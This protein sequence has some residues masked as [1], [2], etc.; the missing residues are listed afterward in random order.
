M[1]LASPTSRKRGFEITS[2]ERF[3][4]SKTSVLF[5]LCSAVFSL[6]GE[7]VVQD[8]FNLT[9]ATNVTVAAGDTLRIEY[10]HG[11]PKIF[12]KKGPGRLEVAVIGNPDIRFVV[13]EGTFAT[14]RPKRMDFGND[15]GV[16][17]HVDATVTDSMTCEEKDGKRLISE[18]RDS[19]GRTF[20]KSVGPYLSRPLPYITE[21]GMNGLPVI[22]FGTLKNAA[23]GDHVGYGAAMNWERSTEG[24][25]KTDVVEYFFAWEDDPN[26]KNYKG[27]YRGASIFGVQGVGWLMTRD[28]VGNGLTASMHPTGGADRRKL[29]NHVD[30]I[31][32]P[33]FYPIPDGPH[34]FNQ[35]VKDANYPLYG[36]LGFGFNIDSGSYGG[37][38][39][40]EFIISEKHF[41]AEL[42]ARTQ[43]YLITRWLGAQF[44]YLTVMP[45]ATLD[46][47]DNRVVTDN[48]NVESG[49][50]VTDWDNID[51][52]YVHAGNAGRSASEASRLLADRSQGVQENLVFAGAAG[53][54]SASGTTGALSRVEGVGVLTKTGSG[55]VL[56]GSVEGGLNAIDIK[57]GT[58]RIAPLEAPGVLLRLDASDAESLELDESGDR[59]V[60]GRWNDANGREGWYAVTN[61]NKYSFDNSRFVGKP[62]LVQN[63][64]NGLPAVDFGAY[65]T[66]DFPDGDGGLL[67]LRGRY[68]NS[69][70]DVAYAQNYFLVWQ[71]RPETI[72]L[73]SDER[74]IMGPSYFGNNNTWYRGFGGKG[75]LYPIHYH[76]APERLNNSIKIDGKTTFFRNAPDTAGWHLMDTWVTFQEGVNISLLGA[77]LY[78]SLKNL[79]KYGNSE[80]NLPETVQTPSVKGIYGGVQIAEAVFFGRELTPAYRAAVAGA[81]GA[82]WFGR[83][84]VREFKSVTLADGT[85]LE[86][87]H[88]QLSATNLAFSGNARLDADLILPN[89]AMVSVAGNSIDGFGT[90]SAFSVKALGTG[91]VLLTASDEAS[92]VK[93]SF[94]LFDASSVTG[95]FSRKV[96]KVEGL[97]VQGIRGTLAVRDGGIWLEFGGCGTVVT[98]R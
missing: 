50:T 24:S 61:A 46:T 89:D 22:D 11:L 87:P 65:T 73:S 55:S 97:K 36:I 37:F 31:A 53:L 54:E 98:L 29:N 26:A 28:T 86:M 42:R 81:L 40:G 90:M 85:A 5:A 60:V 35:W 64:L 17:Y 94:K 56:V 51:V 71:D 70:V 30:G 69:E 82:K 27:P 16:I 63:A 20:I 32:V 41:S 45:G 7:L 74:P 76:D 88:S 93:K 79:H 19:S 44:S 10:L 83:D 58:L 25:S 43:R 23:V 34:V 78:A 15:L 21:N 4:M 59:Q 75:K 67:A 2:T 49:A 14:V 80:P 39:L 68:F 92:L 9:V 33:A 77:N 84:N 8:S 48:L 3:E 38:K 95:D 47:S 62:Y 18:L 96:W 6:R 12:R 72:N 52:R 13:E 91:T 57:A 66:V 1:Q